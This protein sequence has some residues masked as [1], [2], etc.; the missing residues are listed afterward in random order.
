VYSTRVVRV[1]PYKSDEEGWVVQ[2]A[3]S[4]AAQSDA[5][6][7]K[8]LINA[9]GLSGNLI[10]NSLLPPEARIPMY[11]ARG[12][13]ATYS[14][15][16]VSH[17]SSLIYPCPDSVGTE[18]A[19]KGDSASFT[20]LGTHLTLDLNGKIKFGPDVDWIS[21]PEDADEEDFWKHHLVPDGSKIERMRKAITEYLPGVELS[22]LTPDYVGIRPKL[23]PP[24]QFN[25][26]VFHTHY[27]E[28]FL[29]GGEAHSGSAPMISLLGIESP[30]LTS[31]LAIAEMVVDNM[32][33]KQQ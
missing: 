8:C 9:S 31:S 19:Q 22:G 21:P 29:G 27:P 15:P 32:I 16:G 14:G 13:Y 25:D 17:V 1:D 4:G 33:H 28:Q 30:G 11:Y 24:G 6:L 5:L 7:A 10:L 3:T 23:A 2:T 20:G 12:S 18:G 26:F